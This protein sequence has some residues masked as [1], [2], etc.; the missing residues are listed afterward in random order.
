M[1]KLEEIITPYMEN[2]CTINMDSDI[3]ND[4]SINSFDFVNIIMEIENVF[5]CEITN[6]EMNNIR[7][8]KDI[9]QHIILSKI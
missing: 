5:E 7:L 4:L 8:V 6:D 1:N 2:T 3:L 9:V